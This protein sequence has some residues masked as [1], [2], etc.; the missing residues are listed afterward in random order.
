MTVKS[1]PEMHFISFIVY[2][3]YL[4]I[5]FFFLQNY[6][7]LLLRFHQLCFSEWFKQANVN[8]YKSQQIMSHDVYIPVLRNASLHFYINACLLTLVKGECLGQK[9]GCLWGKLFPCP[10]PLDGTLSKDHFNCKLA[11]CKP[12]QRL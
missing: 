1:T 10:T 6:T 11:L 9:L 7:H 5:H 2:F 3:S 12:D 8:I 4:K